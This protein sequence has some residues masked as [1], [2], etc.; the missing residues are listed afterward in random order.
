MRV[1]RCFKKNIELLHIDIFNISLGLCSKKY[2]FNRT[3]PYFDYLIRNPERYC[4]IKPFDRFDLITTYSEGSL[5]RTFLHFFFCKRSCDN[6]KEYCS[7][8]SHVRYRNFQL[9]RMYDYTLL[10]DTDSSSKLGLDNLTV[11][12]DVFLPDLERYCINKKTHCI[13][14]RVINHPADIFILFFSTFV[15]VN[16]NNYYKF[17]LNEALTLSDEKY[18][19]RQISNCVRDIANELWL[20]NVNYFFVIFDVFTKYNRSLCY[21]IQPGTENLYEPLFKPP[22]SSTYFGELNVIPRASYHLFSSHFPDSSDFD[23]DSE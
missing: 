11:D 10:S 3:W 21:N 7:V 14:E 13:R 6:V 20:L 9:I 8:C 22:M 16:L 4:D 15:R 19:I 2:W 17:F 1:S 23:S 12:F 18:T 5:F